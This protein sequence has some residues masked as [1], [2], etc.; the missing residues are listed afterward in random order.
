MFNTYF[1]FLL[2]NF[3]LTLFL[4]LYLYRLRK[5][6]GFQLGMNISMIVGGMLSFTMG[7]IL[8]SLYPLHVAEV[9]I[10]TASIGM[11][12]GGIVGYMFDSQSFL[13]GFSNGFMTGMMAPML[14]ALMTVQSIVFYLIEFFMVFCYALIVIV[15][16]RS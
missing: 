10:F 14:G 9:T 2:G 12:C 5:F 1:L 11:M 4:Y 7:I 8:I 3:C 15:A 16:R 13:T 6:I